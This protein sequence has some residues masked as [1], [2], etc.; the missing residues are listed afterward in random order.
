MGLDRND[1]NKGGLYAFLFCMIASTV[2]FIYIS[3]FHPGIKIDNPK[4]KANVNVNLAEAG[5]GAGAGAAQDMSANPKPWVSSPEFIEYGKSKYK[6]SCAVCHGDSGMGDGPAGASLN[7]PPR[8]FV[9][10]KWK[11]GG[12]AKEL[13][14][15][16]RD[17]LAGTPMA[18]F[19]HIPVVDRWAIVHFIRSISKNAKDD[20]AADLE[21]FAK[22]EK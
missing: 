2:F 19:K 20:N 10:G 18:S 8:N 22:A 15:S 3:Y 6:T 21:N 12:T 16:V 13:F 9:E 5:G 17:G 11:K 1:Y 14:I 7:P 4:L